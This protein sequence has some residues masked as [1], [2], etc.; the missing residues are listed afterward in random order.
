LNQWTEDLAIGIDAI[1]AQHRELYAAVDALHTAMRAHRLDKVGPV[2][3]YL[4]RYVVDHFAAE[5]REMEAARYPGLRNHRSA[6]RSFVKAFVERKAQFDEH[7]ATP[8]LVVDISSWLGEWLRDH[9]RGVDG[10][11]GRYLRSLHGL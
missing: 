3:A 5:E 10:E 6:H 11:M 7:G 9:V 1:D 4:Q 2:L 8:S